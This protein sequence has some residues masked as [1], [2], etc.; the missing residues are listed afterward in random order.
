[1][2]PGSPVT[3]G[4]HPRAVSARKDGSLFKKTPSNREPST[5]QAQVR[6]LCVGKNCPGL[7][8]MASTSPVPP[9]TQVPC[10]AIHPPLPSCL[11]LLAPISSQLSLQFPKALSST[12]RSCHHLPKTVTSRGISLYLAEK[13]KN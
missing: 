8:G 5:F 10:L 2:S 9:N 1:M 7:Q 4:H 13:T 12:G 3:E 6:A 11:G